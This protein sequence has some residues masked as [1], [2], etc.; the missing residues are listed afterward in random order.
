MPLNIDAAVKYLDDN[1]EDGSTGRCAKYVREALD[2]GG[3]SINPHPV[4]AKSYGPYLTLNGFTAVVPKDYAPK[5]GDV[6]VIQ[7]YAGGVDP[8]TTKAYPASDPAGHIAMYDGTQWVSDFK[9]IDMW[10]GPGYRKHRPDFQV[11]RP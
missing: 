6:A 11:Y 1:A 3:L 5:K 8:V 9:Q 4:Y 10:G 2:A 7:D